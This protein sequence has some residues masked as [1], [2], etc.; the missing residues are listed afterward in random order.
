MS[1]DASR[2][3]TLDGL[4]RA[5]AEH[6]P[7][8]VALVDVAGDRRTW[9]YRAWNDRVAR[10]AAEL[11]RLRLGEG[12]RVVVR[13][14][15]SPGLFEEVLALARIGAV[16]VVVPPGVPEPVTRAVSRFTEGADPADGDGLALLQCAGDEVGVPRLVPLDHAGLVRTVRE[17][18]TVLGLD[19]EAD[20]ADESDKSDAGFNAGEGVVHLVARP[21]LT[22]G[23]PGLLDWLAVLCA[24]GRLV[25]GAGG[26]PDSAFRVVA[27]EGVTHT[28][29]PAP[30]AVRWTSAAALTAYDLGSLRTL[31]VSGGGFEERVARRVA[32]AFGCALRQ[33][34]GG[35]EGIVCG[36]RPQDG[37]EAAVTGGMRAVSAG[38][39]LR[40]V[41]QQGRDVP[42]GAEGQLL[43]RGPGP[44]RRY[45]RSPEHDARHFTADG[46]HRT[47]ALAR[48]TDAGLVVV[49]RGPQPSTAVRSTAVRVVRGVPAAADRAPRSHPSESYP[50]EGK[51][52]LT[53]PMFP[54]VMPT[55]AMLPADQTGWALDAARAALV[56]LN[57]QNRFVRTL[58]KEA[59]PVTELLA[60]TR[61]LIET[62]RAAGV[63]V[64]HSVPA[65]VRR[66][67]GRGPVP[68]ARLVDPATGTD[69][70]GFAA[71]AEPRTGD[72][73]L[74]SRKYSAFARTRLD[75]RLRE[76]ERDQVVILGVHA[77]AGVLMTA[78]D[79]WA[80]DLEAFVVADAVADVSAGHHEFALE[81]VADTCGTVIATDRVAAAFGVGH[82][83]AEAV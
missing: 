77:R 16:P 6:H 38:H 43:G 72:T 50:S 79:A 78:A 64:I 68:Y 12:D 51:A 66:A 20:A 39:Q 41:D 21:E 23:V 25:L 62:A 2:H 58:E 48:T 15:G 80:Q 67:G 65:G 71:Q 33:V 22:V 28:V 60:H 26:D 61:R 36:S 14:P 73:V 9:T 19:D 10:R 46:F 4:F 52:E 35:A 30:L 75:G 47:G 82:T 57:L 27:G 56:V 49:V 37:T 17:R 1:T 40:V 55:P 69:A 31:V 76:L 13:L 59:A 5:R 29:L 8:R 42:P 44:E 11:T 32:P 83:A 53:P 54:Y 45:W 7:E 3:T 74:T 24:G 63:P 70:E 81:W 34:F 18:A